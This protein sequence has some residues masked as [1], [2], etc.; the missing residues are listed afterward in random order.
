MRLPTQMKTLIKVSHLGV[1]RYVGVQTTTFCVP[2][3]CV[4]VFSKTIPSDSGSDDIELV[5]V[6][7]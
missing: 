3:F 7:H 1:G 2:A 4:V 6:L 5:A